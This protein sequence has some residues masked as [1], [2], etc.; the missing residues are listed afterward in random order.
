MNIKFLRVRLCKETDLIIFCM[1]M[2]RQSQIY[3]CDICQTARRSH[4]SDISLQ[5]A[6]CLIIDVKLDRFLN[7]G[8]S[9]PKISDPIELEPK[10]REEIKHFEL[11]I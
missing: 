6:E 1:M 7:E 9:L 8:F 11:K 2:M 5:A 3:R 4:A 10:Y